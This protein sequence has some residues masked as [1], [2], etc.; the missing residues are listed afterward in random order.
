MDYLVFG[1]EQDALALETQVFAFGKSVAELNG[2]E[3]NGGIVGKADGISKPENQHT[4][5]WAIPKQRLDGKWVFLSPRY[6]P[7]AVDNETYQQQ[8]GLILGNT[9]VETY[10]DDWFEIEDIA[11]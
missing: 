11:T 3:T 10:S 5:R 2:Y 8:L 7:S 6:H 4:L 9:V 1:S